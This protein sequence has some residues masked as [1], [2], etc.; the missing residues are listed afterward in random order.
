MWRN[1]E[2]VLARNLLAIVAIDQGVKV[3]TGTDGRGTGQAG[4]RESVTNPSA[5]LGNCLASIGNPSRR[6]DMALTD[7]GGSDRKKPHAAVSGKGKRVKGVEP[8]TFTLAT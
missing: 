8:S 5:A 3:A 1:I 6:S 4:W 2:G 7:A